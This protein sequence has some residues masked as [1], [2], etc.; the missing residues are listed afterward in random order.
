MA[1]ATRAELFVCAVRGHYTPGADVEAL[2][3]GSRLVVRRTVDGRRFAQCLR[4]GSWM[5]CD[6]PAAGAGTAAGSLDLLKRP[7]RGQA[8]RQ[9]I[10]LR[11]IAVERAFHAIAFSVT[12]IAALAIRWK[13]DA[14]HGWA[15][16]MLQGVS[17]ARAGQGGLDAR[18]LTAGLLSRL[19]I[20][21][22]HSLSVLAAIASAYAVVSAFE[23]IGL[24]RER[25][26]AEYLTALSAA[27]F[28]P[29]EVHELLARVTFVRVAAT[30]VNLVIILYLVIAKRLLGTS[31]ARPE[32]VSPRVSELPD[33]MAEESTGTIPSAASSPSSPSEP[34]ELAK[35]R[36]QIID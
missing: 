12:A 9:A 2:D 28:L 25:R 18:G 27:S 33:F 10:L 7:R 4:C 31:G 20:V 17:N 24:W 29:I 8:L 35:T 14:I 19:A 5:V 1:E 22:P 15:S 3:G 26:W 11:V 16:S 34:A 30:A 32:P 23:T 13:L 21:N 36:R 6:A